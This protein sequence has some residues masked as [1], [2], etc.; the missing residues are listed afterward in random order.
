MWLW[1]FN[2][3]IKPG[4]LLFIIYQENRLEVFYKE[5]VSHDVVKG[6]HTKNFA[7][8]IWS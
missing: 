2:A 6:S 4:Y 3:T 7:Y 1:F 8:L 5:K